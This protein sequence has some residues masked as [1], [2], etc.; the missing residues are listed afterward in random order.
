MRLG[1]VSRDVFVSGLRLAMLLVVAAP[2]LLAGCGGEPSTGAVVAVKQDN[3]R[4]V[5][6]DSSRP[7]LIE[8]WSNSCEP[9]KELEPQLVSLAQKHRDLLV[10]KIHSEENQS[11]AKDLGVSHVPT[12]LI[13]QNGEEMRRK[14]GNFKPGE[15]AEMV[16]AYVTSK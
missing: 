7:V 9:C 13:F 5:V 6:M 3:F 8:F 15:L 4:S 2:V 16:S 12:V 11:L 10:V 14:V 1:S